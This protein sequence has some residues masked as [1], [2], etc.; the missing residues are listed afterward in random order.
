MPA[1]RLRDAERISA[2]VSDKELL[3]LVAGPHP[4]RYRPGQVAW[5][6]GLAFWTAACLRDGAL[7]RPSPEALRWWRSQLASARF[8]ATPRVARAS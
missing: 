8:E 4:G 3:H 2:Y 1:Q 6:R 7:R 5:R